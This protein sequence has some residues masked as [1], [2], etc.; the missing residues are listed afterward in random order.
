[1][2]V[3]DLNDE[4]ALTTAHFG[5]EILEVEEMIAREMWDA[6]KQKMDPMKLCLLIPHLSL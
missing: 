6:V 4:Q 2:C 5:D 3:Q 1:M